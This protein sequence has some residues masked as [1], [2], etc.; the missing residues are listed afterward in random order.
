VRR[1]QADALRL[2]PF[3]RSPG[4]PRPSVRQLQADAPS[5][6]PS[7]RFPEG[8]RP[9]MQRVRADALRHCPSDRFRS[10]AVTDV[11]KRLDCPTLGGYAN[12]RRARGR[13]FLVAPSAH[14]LRRRSDAELAL[15]TGSTLPTDSARVA[16]DPHRALEATGCSGL[17]PPSTPAC[18]TAATPTQV[19]ARTGGNVGSSSEEPAPNRLT[20]G[21]ATNNSRRTSARPNGSSHRRCRR[22]R[23]GAIVGW[24]PL[25]R[26][27]VVRDSARRREASRCDVST[28]HGA[29]DSFRAAPPEG[30]AA[31][32]GPTDRRVRSSLR[33]PLA[34]HS[35]ELLEGVATSSLPMPQIARHLTPHL[36]PRATPAA[37]KPPLSSATPSEELTPFD[38]L[39]AA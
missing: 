8:S 31:W 15:H 33:G 6:C 23:P 36:E 13:A 3:D 39:A 19:P 26:K 21:R 35:A 28:R 2:C 22:R 38:H 4:G 20:H 24:R 1:F 11:G 29:S 10:D 17:L 37:R 34:A 14:R 25:A 18:A 16:N 12:P 30:G 27:R 9:S 7:D 5:R 32:S